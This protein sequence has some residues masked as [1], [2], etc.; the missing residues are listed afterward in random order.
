MMLGN[1]DL[2]LRIMMLGNPDLSLRIMMLGNPRILVFYLDFHHSDPHAIV[3]GLREGRK[4]QAE[5]GGDVAAQP[6]ANERISREMQ[7]YVIY[8]AYSIIS[9]RSL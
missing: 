3:N 1:P 6:T 5:S 7:R 9:V 8:N 2:P 4:Q